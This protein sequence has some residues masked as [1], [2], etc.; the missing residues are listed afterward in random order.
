M[1]EASPSLFWNSRNKPRFWKRKRWLCQFLVYI[2]YSKCNFN[3]IYDRQLQNVHCGALFLLTKCLWKCPRSTK[4]PLPWNIYGCMP[5]LRHYSIC[6]TL[7]LKS[8]TVFWICICL[9]NCSVICTVT[10]S[11]ALHYTHSE[12]WHIQ[13]SFYSDI[14][15]HTQAYSALL[16]HIHAYWVIL[17]GCSG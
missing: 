12:F 10:L 4:P 11:Y 3:S 9:N 14:L 6:K 17:K 2:F 1:A 16:R 7:H 13:N 5:A 15:M 8:L